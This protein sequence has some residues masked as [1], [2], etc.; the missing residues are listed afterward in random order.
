MCKEG[1]LTYRELNFV[2]HD[3]RGGVPIGSENAWERRKQLVRTTQ[4]RIDQRY[5]QYCD[6]SQKIPRV[7]KMVAN[8]IVA[9]LWLTIY[10]PLIQ[11]E[12]V[13]P[14]DDRPNVLVLST[15][16]LDQHYVFFQDPSAMAVR[17]L[18]ANYLQWHPL[19]ITLA[20]LCT[21]TEGPLVERAW[22]IAEL[23]Y[24]IV[25]RDIA[26]T[27]RGMRWQPIRKLMTKARKVR[28]AALQRKRDVATQ[29]NPTNSFDF[30]Q[31]RHSSTPST[32]TMNSFGTPSTVPFTQS[33]GIPDSAVQTAIP[34][35]AFNWDPWLCANSETSI[36]YN[37]V[38]AWRNWETFIDEFQGES[39]M[40]DID[41]TQPQTLS[42][43]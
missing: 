21:Q 35:E 36:P 42:E 33:M 11:E 41:F 1:Y 24:N 18:T 22:R 34:Q 30:N 26:D 20:E 10:R 27:S 32:A 2:L 7:T 9:T 13:V 25:A 5:I 39:L 3:D 15:E 16:L 23:Y 8:N 37:A 17:W 40:E 12:I 4:Q 43:I 31:G 38:N 14:P 28:Q 19:A 6:M 29:A